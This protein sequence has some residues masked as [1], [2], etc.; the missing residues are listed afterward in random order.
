LKRNLSAWILSAIVLLAIVFIFSNS[1][2][3][4]PESKAASGSVVQHMK[5]ALDLIPGLDDPEAR[6]Y[7]VRKGAHL[8]EFFL[9]GVF[10]GSLVLIM[11]RRLQKSFWAHALF[12]ALLVAVCDEFIQNFTGRSSE[13]SDVLIDFSGALLGFAA[14]L[15]T[16]GISR[17]VIRR[18][19][20]EKPEKKGGTRSSFE[21]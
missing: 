6:E 10:G 7:V 15:L 12:F 4:G 2:Q 19:G 1:L 14:V 17:M 16:W 3:N 8:F 18:R 21:G 11:R 13:V 20:K 9:L 5:P